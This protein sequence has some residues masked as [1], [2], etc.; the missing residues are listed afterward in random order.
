MTNC[1]N[2]HESLKM[3][4]IVWDVDDVLNDLTRVWFEHWLSMHPQCLVQ[5][6]ALSENPPH[7][8]L[9]ISLDSY[10]ASLDTFRL[11]AAG[12]QLPPNPEVIAWFREYGHRFRHI[13]LTA[14]PLLS[15]SHQ[16]QWVIHHYGNWIRSF[17]F[18]PSK[19]QNYPALE[20]DCTK[21]DYLRWWGRADILVEDNAANAK[22][23]Y[24]LGIEV[25]LMPRP[26]NQSSLT[27]SGLL[28]SLAKQGID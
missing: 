4:T 18:V 25:L 1:A 20:Y 9:G 10:L 15:A 12:Q 23:A 14:V 26:W 27:V 21:A 11:S 13:A 5:Y 6:E 17:N 2:R 22:A 24:Q 3:K 8:L 19:R 16:A 28:D 7:A